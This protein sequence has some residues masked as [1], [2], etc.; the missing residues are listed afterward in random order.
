MQLTASAPPVPIAVP[1]AQMEAVTMIPAPRWTI[2]AAGGLQRSFD[3]GNTWQDVDVNAV[4][5]IGSYSTALEVMAPSTAVKKDKDADRKTLKRGTSPLTFLAVAAAG[6]EVWAGGT[7]GTLYHSVDSGA[8]WTRVVP[9][10]AGTVLLS[11]I[12][13]LDFPDAQHG[14]I[15][16]STTEVWSTTDGGQ[17]WQKQ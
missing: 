13:G 7:G 6:A 14:K 17:T 12:V 10:S 11:D 2:T 5:A 8:R 9:A 15:T 1:R 16:T 4:S 3:Q